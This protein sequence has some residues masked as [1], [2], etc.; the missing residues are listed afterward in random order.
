[1]VTSRLDYGN[2]VLIGLPTHLVCCLQLM[3]NAATD[4]DIDADTA[5][6]QT[7]T[8]P[9]QSLQNALVTLHWLRLPESVIYKIAILTFRVLHGIPPEYLGPAVRSA[10]QPG[11]QALHSPG[12]NRLVVPTLK[13]STIGRPTRAFSVGNPHVWN[14][15]PTIR[16]HHCCPPC[17][18]DWKLSYS[19][20][21]FHISLL[22]V[23]ANY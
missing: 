5:D 22:S 1:M 7:S 13:L 11:G 10:D 23:V 21:H 17:V 20:D 2:G 9:S 15:L 19:D 4:T 8:L 12:T 3:Q 6:L 14:I 18:E 16:R